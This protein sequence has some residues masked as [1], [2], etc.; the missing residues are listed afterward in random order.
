MKEGEGGGVGEDEMRWRALASGFHLM[1]QRIN[2]PRWMKPPPTL[3]E[4]ICTDFDRRDDV[5]SG[6]MVEGCDSTSSMS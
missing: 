5:I 6:F 2:L 1:T 4:V 3:K